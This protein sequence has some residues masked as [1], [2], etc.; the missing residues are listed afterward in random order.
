MH[1]PTCHCYLFSMTGVV[2]LWV[3]WNVD[4]KSILFKARCGS[5]ATA[6]LLA[7]LLT[8]NAVFKTYP[9]MTNFIAVF[10]D[11]TKNYGTAKSCGMLRT[12]YRCKLRNRWSVWFASSSRI[13]A[14]MCVSAASCKVCPF[15]HSPSLGW[16]TQLATSS[17]AVMFEFP[18]VVYH[19]GLWE[20]HFSSLQP[21]QCACCTPFSRPFPPEQRLP[22]RFYSEIYRPYILTLNFLWHFPWVGS[23][24][25]ASS[26]RMP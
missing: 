15:S 23:V 17:Y 21:T 12:L 3:V 13:V 14:S 10:V 20:H 9:S 18:Y 11:M 7:T 2:S 16:L 24:L 22:I 8:L 26:R 1:K 5:N 6:P 4:R 19:N 25:N